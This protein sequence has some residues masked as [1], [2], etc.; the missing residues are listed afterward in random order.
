MYVYRLPKISQ[1]KMNDQIEQSIQVVMMAGICNLTTKFNH[2]NATEVKYIRNEN[3]IEVIRLEISN[4]Y[5]NMQKIK[6]TLRL[7]VLL[8][9]T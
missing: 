1:I 6:F 5:H 2:K 9:L 8:Q 3:Y 4:L 7:H